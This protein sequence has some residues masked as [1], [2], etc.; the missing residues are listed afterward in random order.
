VAFGDVESGRT[1]LLRLLV[2]GIADRYPPSDAAVVVADYRRGLLEAVP[3][4]HLLEYCGAEPALTAVLADVAKGMRARLPGPAVTAEQ[5]RHRSWW[6]G[7]ELFVVV[8]DYDLVAGQGGSPLAVL[9]EFL[10]QA[11]D[12]GLHLVVARR[13]G[14]A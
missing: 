8:D 11:R 13:S 5:L 4:A 2:R 6:S 3:A 14:G 10:P 12:I 7:P 1:A 9:A